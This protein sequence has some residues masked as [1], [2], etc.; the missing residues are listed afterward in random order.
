M[1]K[2][3]LGIALCAMVS[4]E[5]LASCAWEEGNY[6][7]AV[8]EYARCNVNCDSKERAVMQAKA[9]FEACYMREMQHEMFMQRL[10]R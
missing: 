2:L 10:Q 9:K 3:V 4:S 1:K 5:S 7:R 8:D 6:K